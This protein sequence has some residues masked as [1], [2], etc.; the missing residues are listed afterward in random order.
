MSV[1]FV[2]N[3]MLNSW[4]D[5][6]KVRLADTTLHLLAEGRTIELTPAVRVVKLIDGSDDP[7]HLVGKVKTAQQLHAMGA[8]HY[9]DSVICGDVGYYVVEGFRGALS[10][11]P[12]AAV[13]A[14]KAVPAPV[15]IRTPPPAPSP[16]APPSM[17]PPAAPPALAATT[18][19]PPRATTLPLNVKLELEA[20]ELSKVFLDTVRDS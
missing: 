15:E 16:L 9:L 8:E 1:V 20:M 5:Q 12:G 18:P 13:A 17:A 11:G 6:G 14:P 3:A 2:T 19:A 10:P 4:T 7:H